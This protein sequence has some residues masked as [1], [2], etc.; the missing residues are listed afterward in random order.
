MALPLRL[1]LQP[2]PDLDFPGQRRVGGTVGEVHQTA[3]V[4][5][6]GSLTEVDG[7]GHHIRRSGIDIDGVVV[8]MTEGH[9]SMP[10][11]D[12][13]SLIKPIKLFLGHVSSRL[14]G[15][16]EIKLKFKVN[17]NRLN[18][19]VSVLL[20]VC[21]H[22]GVSRF[23]LILLSAVVDVELVVSFLQLAGGT[24]N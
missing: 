24:V 17:K 19:H 18:L 7:A 13:A 23:N 2:V 12:R 11:H 1:D 16:S 8:S 10:I 22:R 14:E 9:R 5:G 21:E 15:R 6:E 4:G 20:V 3:H